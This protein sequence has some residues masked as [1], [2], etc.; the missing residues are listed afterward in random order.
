MGR[1]MRGMGSWAVLLVGAALSACGCERVPF[2]VSPGDGGIDRG[3]GSDVRG[4]GGPWIVGGSDSGGPASG[5]ASGSGGAGI[6]DA[7]AAGGG[8]SG[9]HD[10]GNGDGGGCPTSPVVTSWLLGVYSVGVLDV[11]AVGE[12]GAILHYDG[13]WRVEVS[14]TTATLNSVWA[15]PGGVVW[16]VGDG[17]ITVRREAGVWSI[18]PA[19]TSV[20]LSGVWG[21]SA[22]D[23]WAVAGGAILHWNGAAWSVSF[24]RTKGGFTSVSG[25]SA[26]DVSV[27]GSGLQPD[28]DYASLILHW[29]GTAWTESYVCAPEGSRFASDGF[30]SNLIDVW[31]VAGGSVWAVGSC[32]SPTDQQGFVSRGPG[33]LWGSSGP[34]PLLAF[35]YVDAVWASS[36]T[37]V[38]VASAT[39][40]FHDILPTIVHFDGTSWTE[41][42]DPNT[43]SIFDL[44]GTGANDI[45]AVGP[46]GKR[47]HFDGTSWT[48]SP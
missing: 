41:S 35:H 4:S 10:G 40:P 29:D 36:D 9:A 7:G 31:S 19:P 21:A 16:A 34:A 47:L 12:A 17:G 11:W 32:F 28:G 45:W 24:K 46:A 42:S 30:V 5:G 15:G 39:G 23:V 43:M 25:T 2:V 14:P 8:G 33:E 44:G 1:A 37:D 13:C 48:R 6:G 22:A 26:D 27:V 18:V 3:A 20:A 38:W